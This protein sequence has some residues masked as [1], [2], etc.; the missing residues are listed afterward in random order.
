MVWPAQAEH[1]QRQ[2]RHLPGL[3]CSTR[4]ALERAIT[5]LNQLRRLPRVDLDAADLGGGDLG[6]GGGRRRRERRGRG[7]GAGAVVVEV[8]VEDLMQQRLRQERVV[9]AQGQLLKVFF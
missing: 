1:L 2:G 5:H 3:A 6:G 9:V 8:V 4:Q 7:R